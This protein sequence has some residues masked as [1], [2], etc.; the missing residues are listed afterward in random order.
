MKI[1]TLA[2]ALATSTAVAAPANA[3]L[4]TKSFKVTSLFEEGPLTTVVTQFDLTFD[5]SL[6]DSSMKISLSNFKSDGGVSFSNP[7]AIYSYSPGFLDVRPAIRA[8]SIG[9]E[10]SGPEDARAN[11]NDFYI[12]ID[13]DEAGN[14]L[15]AYSIYSHATVPFVVYARSTTSDDPVSTSMPTGAVPEPATWAMMLVGFGLI[16]GALRYRRKNTTIRYA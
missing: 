11:S 8:L 9:G 15:S 3:A 7:Q 5:P 2:L 10:I 13:V 12:G 1:T 14:A 16:G 4:I 6:T